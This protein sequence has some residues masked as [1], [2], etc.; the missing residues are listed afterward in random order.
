MSLA[1]ARSTDPHATETRCQARHQEVYGQAPESIGSAPATWNLIGE[2]TDSFGGVVIL[3]LGEARAW[4]A[5]SRR[6]DDIIAVDATTP[7]GRGR[8]ETSWP[9]VEKQALAADHPV[10]TQL[11][12]K[13]GL[14][15]WVMVHRQ[16]VSRDVTGINVTAVSEVPDGMGLGEQDAL[17]V[18]LAMAL[19]ALSPGTPDDPPNRS[20]IADCCTQAARI[21]SR[22]PGLRARRWAAL[23][24]QSDR[25]AVINYADGSLTPRPL[26]PEATLTPLVV[27]AQAP[28]PQVL[29]S[30]EDIFVYQDRLIDSA[31]KAF[32][33]QSLRHLP[34]ASDRVTQWLAARQ[35]V[36]GDKNLPEVPLARRW[37]TWWERET[38][39]ATSVASGLRARHI[40]A[41][42][43][44]VNSSHRDL[45]DSFL[46]PG[47]AAG[48]PAVRT[49]AEALD[50]GAISARLASAG[51]TDACIACVPQPR[52]PRWA[53]SLGDA[54]YRVTAVGNGE[55]ATCTPM[56]T[57]E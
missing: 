3:G 23:R 28:T 44:L 25:L 9:R 31:A 21:S 18:A 30:Y 16:F 15:L 12:E 8:Q 34:E 42:F 24:G 22:A 40:D 45:I 51:V 33:A 32:N 53:S 47:T 19:A 13:L 20:R 27:R 41:A 2:H 5:V 56:R 57:V 4:C 6:T 52:V 38:A 43:E 11:A 10:T 7:S 49:G 54:G 26:P 29:S 1:G 46:A 50:A 17:E 37:L 48:P 39:R 36:V 35:E 14:V 55:P